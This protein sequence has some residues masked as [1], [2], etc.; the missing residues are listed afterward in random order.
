MEQV[1]WYGSHDGTLPLPSSP[2][3]QLNH[4]LDGMEQV[5]WY[6]SNDGTLPLPFPSGW[7]SMLPLVKAAQCV[8]L[9]GVALC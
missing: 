7:G 5:V 2:S 3:T 6:G 8:C 9:H 4:A 1:V